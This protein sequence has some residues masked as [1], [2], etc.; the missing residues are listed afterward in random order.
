[1][2]MDRDVR[3]LSLFPF[4]AFPHVLTKYFWLLLF[5]LWGLLLS[6][7]TNTVY[8][9]M[10]T[11]KFF[12]AKFCLWEGHNK[13]NC[14]EPQKKNERETNNCHHSG[15]HDI[16]ILFFNSGGHGKYD[17]EYA[18]KVPQQQQALCSCPLHGK[19]HASI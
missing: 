12:F 5:L 18:G 14:I 11:S 2:T 8:V 7:Y 3:S 19:L 16:F 9:C 10:C 13:I 15:G 1:M 4:L 17:P 6:L